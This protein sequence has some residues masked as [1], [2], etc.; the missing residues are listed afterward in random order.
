[1]STKTPDELFEEL[2]EY[3]TVIVIAQFNEQGLPMTITD[4]AGNQTEPPASEEA[5]ENCKAYIRENIEYKEPTNVQCGPEESHCC[6][7][8]EDV[9]GYGTP[10]AS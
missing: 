2:Y 8:P 6:C 10:R 4:S 3:F 5:E 9:A 1:M 7:R